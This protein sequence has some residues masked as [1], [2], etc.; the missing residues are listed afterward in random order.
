MTSGPAKGLRWRSQLSGTLLQLDRKP[1]RKVS[2]LHPVMTFYQFLHIHLRHTI[3]GAECFILDSEVCNPARGAAQQMLQEV[4]AHEPWLKR[5]W[6][7][8]CS[9]AGMT[10]RP[11]LSHFWWES[12]PN[13]CRA[14]LGR[15]EES[16]LCLQWTEATDVPQPRLQLDHSIPLELMYFSEA[17]LFIFLT[18]L[19]RLFKC[20]KG[21]SDIP[22]PPLSFK[23]S[24]SIL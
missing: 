9:R 19:C 5:A 20:S 17:F 13:K 1:H 22:P 12:N 15:R 2:I 11:T 23:K 18:K 8:C 21:D 4:P 3:Q 6:Q 16:S 10:H 7:F 24:G 14:A